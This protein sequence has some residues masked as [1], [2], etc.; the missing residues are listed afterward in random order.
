MARAT[1]SNKNF[2]ALKCAY[3]YDFLDGDTSLVEKQRSIAPFGGVT[4]TLLSLVG[5]N[6]LT[7]SE[8]RHARRKA[9]HYADTTRIKRVLL[10]FWNKTFIQPH[11]STSIFHKSVK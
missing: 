7:F 11:E 6:R 10:N 4:R 1:S 9:F 8:Q 2:V 5:L 3:G